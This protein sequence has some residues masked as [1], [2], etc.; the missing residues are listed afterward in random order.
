MNAY[1]WVDPRPVSEEEHIACRPSE[2]PM[3]A[4]PCNM[5]NCSESVW[6]AGSWMPVSVYS[7]TGLCMRNIH[8][9]TSYFG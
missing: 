5:G 7:S 2:K 1:H 6:R 4:R 9:F 8:T 3:T